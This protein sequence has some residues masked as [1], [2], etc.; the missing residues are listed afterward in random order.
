MDKSFFVELYRTVSERVHP[1]A[2]SQEEWAAQEKDVEL[3]ED[4]VEAAHRRACLEEMRQSHYQV[5]QESSH[6][7][8][9]LL[10]GYLVGLWSLLLFLVYPKQ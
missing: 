3:L 8:V 4:P 9:C 1:C 2:V 10:C 6:A 7:E 5:S